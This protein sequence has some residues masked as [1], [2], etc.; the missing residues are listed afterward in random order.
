MTEWIV[1]ASVPKV[2]PINVKVMAYTQDQAIAQV[3]A[4]YSGVSISVQGVRQA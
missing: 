4:M 3:K 2:G 1:M